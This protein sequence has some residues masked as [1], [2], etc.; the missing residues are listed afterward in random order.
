MTGKTVQYLD[1]PYHERSGQT[2]VRLFRDSLRT[3]QYILQAI[4]YYN[5]LKIFILFAL[6]CFIGALSGFC[7]SAFLGFTSG[8]LLGVGGLLTCIVIICFG[9]IADLLKQIMDK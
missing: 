6:L 2:K 5:P 8:F 1:I 7:I 3:L 4:N 9:L